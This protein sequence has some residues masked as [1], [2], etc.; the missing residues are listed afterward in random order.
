MLRPIVA[1][2]LLGAAVG[3][4]LAAGVGLARAEGPSSTV[5]IDN[6]TFSP[7]ELKVKAGTTVTG[8]ITTISRT[9]SPRRT[10]PLRSRRRST[11]TTAIPLRSP[12][13]GPTNTSVIYTPTW[14]AR[15]SSNRQRAATLRSDVAISV[16][17]F[18]HWRRYAVSNFGASFALTR[19]CRTLSTITANSLEPTSCA[20]QW[21][22]P[23]APLR[24]EASSRELARR[25]HTPPLTTRARPQGAR[26]IARRASD[27]QTNQRAVLAR[28][29]RPIKPAPICKITPIIHQDAIM[30]SKLRCRIWSNTKA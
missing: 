17:R 23:I 9:A 14:W 25:G 27:N 28:R 3:S 16:L 30:Y 19:D 29:M 18:T 10:T 26:F 8:L 1:T 12:R 15:S 4:V 20:P 22:L 6:F 7:K 2:F 11:P 13:R 21:Q 24:L 5:S